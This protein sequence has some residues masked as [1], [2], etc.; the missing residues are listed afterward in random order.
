MFV[1]QGLNAVFGIALI[2]IGI[3]SELPP[4]VV[5]GGVLLVFAAVLLVLAWRA[6]TSQPDPRHPGRRP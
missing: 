3:S 2:W 6:Q 5:V 4:V 1:L